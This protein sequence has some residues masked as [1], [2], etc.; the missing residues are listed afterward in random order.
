MIFMALC[1]TVFVSLALTSAAADRGLTNRTGETAAS[2]YGAQNQFQ[3][4]LSDL[5]TRLLDM[6]SQGLTQGNGDVEGLLREGLQS[7]LQEGVSYDAARHVISAQWPAGERLLLKADVQINSAGFMDT[8]PRYTVTSVMLSPVEESFYT[9][10]DN[11]WNGEDFS[12]D[13]Q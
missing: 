7:L 13:N 5:D 12:Y 9:P 1:L 11:M 8:G 6:M 10:M 2:Y 3:A 4:F